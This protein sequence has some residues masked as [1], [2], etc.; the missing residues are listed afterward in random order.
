MSKIHADAMAPLTLLIESNL[1]FHRLEEIIKKTKDPREIPEF[2]YVALEEE[3]V[4]HMTIICEIFKEYGDM[5]E[6]PFD[7]K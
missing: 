5:K 2:R 6:H 4:K 3:F 7:I 1:Q